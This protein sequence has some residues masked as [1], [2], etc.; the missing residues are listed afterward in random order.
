MIYDSVLNRN[1]EKVSLDYFKITQDWLE[2]RKYNKNFNQI[3]NYDL[4]QFDDNFQPIYDYSPNDL[5]E[6][7]YEQLFKKRFYS[8]QSKSFNPID[9]IQLKRDSDQK[10]LSTGKS[11]KVCFITHYFF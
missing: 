5:F 3:N 4:N 1:V 9:M 8:I 2:K 7:K 6:K 11:I 10:V